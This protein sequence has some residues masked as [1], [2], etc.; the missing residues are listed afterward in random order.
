MCQ[1]YNA[2]LSKYVMSFTSAFCRQQ[3][4]E[5]VPLN[6]Y[7]KKAA[8]CLGRQPSSN[9]WVLNEETHIDETGNK[10]STSDSEYIWIG[11]MIGNRN[12]PNVAPASDAA[13]VPCKVV[14]H[15]ALG[16]TLHCLKEA[17]DN[18][19]VPAFFIIASA[20]MAVHYEVVNNNY[21]ICPTPVGIGPKNMGKSTA[22]RTALALLGTPQFFV[23]EFT[24]AQTANSIV[25]RLSPQ[26]LK[27]LFN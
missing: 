12:L 22:A 21:G 4:E 3:K 6:K 1:L 27:I 18:N 26:C 9:V 13:I 15:D 25:A 8:V 17:V 14:P 5:G 24:S 10:I 20:G 16:N 23:H 7:V 11:G 2:E 19:F